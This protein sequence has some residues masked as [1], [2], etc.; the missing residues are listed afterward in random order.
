VDLELDHLFV[1]G[2]EVVSSGKVEDAAASDHL[3]I[4]LSVRL[5]QPGEGR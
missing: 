1:K 5:E 3:P 4:W 2:M